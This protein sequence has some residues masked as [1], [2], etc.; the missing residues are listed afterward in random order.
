MT[1]WLF[2]TDRLRL[3]PINS[4]DA[5]NLYALNSDPDVMTFLGDEPTTLKANQDVLPRIIARNK[6]HNDKLGL[7]MAHLKVNNEFIGW[8][9]LRPDPLEQTTNLEIGYR[10]RKIYWGQGY[11]TEGSRSLLD[12]AIKT[13]KPKRIFATTMEKNL[14]SVAVMKKIGLKFEKLYVEKGFED[15]GEMDVLYSQIY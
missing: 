10:L 9:L 6:F 11:A 15:S 2:E 5:T 13:F 7:F 12:Y 4:D 14:A 1:D 8:F 3:R